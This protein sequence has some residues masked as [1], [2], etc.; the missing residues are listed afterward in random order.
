MVV[1]HDS[2]KLEPTQLKLTESI[3]PEG[4]RGVRSV[5]HS[6]YKPQNE[7]YYRVQVGIG[8][9]SQRITKADYV[10]G[11]LSSFEKLYFAE[12][13]GGIDAVWTEIEEAARRGDAYRAREP[14]PHPLP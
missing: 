10:L 6:V 1:I 4:H 14:L 11:S 13:A 9:Y 2:L 7:R 12:N 3:S 8:Q 5:N